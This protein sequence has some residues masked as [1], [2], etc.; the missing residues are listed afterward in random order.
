MKNFKKA[1]IGIVLLLAMIFL[2]SESTSGDIMTT[3]FIKSIG[4]VLIICV[5]SL[6]YAFGL[7]KDEDIKHFLDDD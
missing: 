1:I 3:I 2:I 7:D 5:P 6:W 4:L